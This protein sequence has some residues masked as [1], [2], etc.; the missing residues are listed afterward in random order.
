MNASGSINISLVIDLF[1][2]GYMEIL[3]EIDARG[4]LDPYLQR[5]Y[6]GYMNKKWM[7]EVRS[8]AES[9]YLHAG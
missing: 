9:I 1:G 8:G 6:E 3:E 2:K 5:I 7:E 4:D